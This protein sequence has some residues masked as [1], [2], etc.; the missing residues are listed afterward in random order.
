VA[1]PGPLT[2][3]G[4]V[5]VVRWEVRVRVGEAGT[6]VWPTAG[7]LPAD[8]IDAVVAHL[9]ADPVLAAAVGGRV[10]QGAAGH[11]EELPY[12]QVI[13]PHAE[14]SGGLTTDDDYRRDGSLDINVYIEDPGDGSFNPDDRAR[15][16]AR[17][18]AKSLRDAPLTFEAG[19]L[20]YLRPAHHPWGEED[21]DPGPNGLPV[22]HAWVSMQYIVS[23]NYTE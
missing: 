21:P 9:L 7:T 19:R 18:A 13:D 14:I 2:T 10:W 1:E 15:T 22:W 11:D 12:I 6:A 23:G 17:R 20:A 16:I 5:G 8:L 3:V 4:T